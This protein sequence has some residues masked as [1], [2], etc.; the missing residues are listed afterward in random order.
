MFSLIRT[1]LRFGAIGLVGAGV[2]AGGA[3][4][5]AGPKRSKV[6]FHKVQDQVMASIDECIDDPT[7]LRAQLQEL[8]QEYPE[9][10]GQVRGDLAEIQAQIRQLEREQAIAERVVSMAEED[11][12]ELEPLVAQAGN[13]VRDANARA[14]VVC[15]KSKVFSVERASAHLNQIRHTQLA[16]ASR[17]GEAGFQL[18]DYPAVAAWI[19]RVEAQPG[20]GAPMY[21][22]SLDPHSANEPGGSGTGP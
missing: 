1:F 14:A 10:I 19:A 16:Y 21:P 17:A 4:L 12:A 11:L 22:Y 20:F 3:L 15:F 13:Q 7:A 18:A 8:E 6:V 9:R 5:I 2:L